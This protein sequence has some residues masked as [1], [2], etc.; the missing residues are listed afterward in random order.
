MDDF[1][2]DFLSPSSFSSEENVFFLNLEKEYKE[3]CINPKS[4]F[5]YQ[6]LN[7]KTFLKFKEWSSQKLI[8]RLKNETII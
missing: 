7:D 1:F 2:K 3:Y 8:L 6:L 4:N 5:P